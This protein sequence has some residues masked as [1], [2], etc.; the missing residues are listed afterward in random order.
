MQ[1]EINVTFHQ[2]GTWGG[3]TFSA[4]LVSRKCQLLVDIF[5]DDAY[6]EIVLIIDQD[7]GPWSGKEYT[8][9]N[10]F[11]GLF[12]DG[13]NNPF[14]GKLFKGEIE[15]EDFKFPP[16]VV[17]GLPVSYLHIDGEVTDAQREL[18]F[19]ACLNNSP[20]FCAGS[21]V[22]KLFTVDEIESCTG[23]KQYFA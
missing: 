4:R 15:I 2:Q 21:T 17:F 6:N 8:H 20:R 13:Y 16:A 5:G 14:A 3:Q 1:T 12:A 10:H 22:M 11:Q 19:E 9:R 18:L 23:K 7:N